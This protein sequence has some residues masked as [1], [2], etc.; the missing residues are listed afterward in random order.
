MG[1]I[2]IKNARIVNE[3][4]VFVGSL[5]IC[6]DTIVDIIPKGKSL[7]P[8]VDYT[9][10]A[11]YMY[12]FPG[13]IDDHVHFREPGLTHKATMASESAAAAADGITTIFDMPNTIPPTTSINHL[14][15]KYDIAA[16]NC[17]VNHS[18]YFGA[19]GSNLHLI[20]NLD[21]GSVCGVKVFM[22]SSTG[23]MLL[24]D[25]ELLI[26]LFKTSPV[27]I[28]A[29]CEDSSIINANLAKYKT[30]LQG[31]EPDITCHPLIRSAEACYRSSALAIELAHQTDA[32]LHILHVSTAKE[33]EL[34]QDTP[35]DDK[36]ITAEVS[37]AHL[38]FHQDYYKT[39]GS[40]IKCNPA[41]KSKDDREA[42]RNSLKS[43]KIDVVGTDHAPHLLNEKIGGSISAASGMPILPYSLPSLLELHSLGYISLTEIVQKMCHNPAIIFNIEKRGFIRKGYKADLVLVQEKEEVKTVSS[44]D[45]TNLCGWT[46]FEGMKF[47]WSVQQTWV[48]GNRIY[49]DGEISKK[50]K[51]EKITFVR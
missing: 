38:M 33:L 28:A 15:D 51:G 18:F 23:D 25:K 13:I 30:L 20:E 7:P 43:N 3:K 46:P 42:L 12:L 24:D 4:S 1:R 26:R 14:Q 27:P 16:E 9:V 39:L 10:D 29:H 48:N 40:R 6:G 31:E 2:L 37:P 36:L 49:N 11:R 21:P 45:I 41:I 22:G 32:R 19:T 8:T 35:P 44:S 17:L 34:F 50:H 47:K 5:L